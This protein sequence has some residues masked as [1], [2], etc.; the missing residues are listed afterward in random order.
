M[1]LS[2]KLA[3][4]SSST[5]H[6]AGR[7]LLLSSASSGMTLLFPIPP[8][9]QNQ[10]LNVQVVLALEV[11]F[12]PP[13][14]SRFF[15]LQNFKPQRQWCIKI[16]SH[17]PR[18]FIHHWCF[19]GGESIRGDCSPQRWWCKKNPVSDFCSLFF[20]FFLLFVIIFLCV[21]LLCLRIALL[22]RALPS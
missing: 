4:M 22:F 6:T 11:Q 10:C 12:A 14:I 21:P 2:P 5:K 18:N 9:L 20:Q 19:G 3:W 16:P 17:G 1:Q 13:C 7:G 8:I 15:Y